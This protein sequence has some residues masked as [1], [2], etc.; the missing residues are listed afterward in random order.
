[1]APSS[2]GLRLALGYALL[3]L[4]QEPE[5]SAQLRYACRLNPRTLD[6]L[7]GL[8]WK[9]A[10]DLSAAERNGAAA[11]KLAE[12]ACDLTGHNK[13]IYLEV[14]AAGYAEVGR[15]PDAIRTAERAE[16]LVL[17]SGDSDGTMHARQLLDRL[18]TGQPWRSR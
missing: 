14:L 12:Q 10:T 17:A 5:A 6:Q 2:P 7:A 9:L 15:Y 13:P 8:A 18:R 16:T 11:V 1:M 3:L 4:D